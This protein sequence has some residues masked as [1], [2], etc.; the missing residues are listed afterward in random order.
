[1]QSRGGIGDFAATKVLKDLS[2]LTKSWWQKDC[3]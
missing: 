2:N 1:M 3:L